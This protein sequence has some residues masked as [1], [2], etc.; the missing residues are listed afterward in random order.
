MPCLNYM[1]NAQVSSLSWWNIV[2]PEIILIIGWDKT[3]VRVI[4]RGNFL[5]IKWQY[6]AKMLQGIWILIY[7]LMRSLKS[8]QVIKRLA[9]FFLATCSVSYNDPP[10]LS[11]SLSLH[12]HDVD[13]IILTICHLVT[14][15]FTHGFD[16]LSGQVADTKILKAVLKSTQRDKD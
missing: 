9:C 6:R 10:N 8:A 12:H 3:Q 2:I 1:L 5:R 15:L 7:E 16:P 11:L 14:F 4:L 13:I